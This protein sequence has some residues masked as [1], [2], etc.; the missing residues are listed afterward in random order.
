MHKLN[1]PASYSLAPKEVCVPQKYASK[2]NGVAKKDEKH[3]VLQVP[4]KILLLSIPG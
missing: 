1:G 2:Y 3:Q 4:G